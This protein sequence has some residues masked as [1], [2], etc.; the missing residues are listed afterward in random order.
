MSPLVPPGQHGGPDGLIDAEQPVRIDFSSCVNALGPAPEVIAAVRAARLDVYPDP[1]CRAA[2]EAAAAYCQVPPD[3]VTCGAGAAELIL[4]AARA[5]LSPGDLALVCAPAFGEYARAAAMCGAR[6]HE[7]REE[8]TGAIAALIGGLRPRI[9][10]IAC[11]TSPAGRAYERAQLRRVADAC[12][13][14][15]A[16]LVLDQSYD[17]FLDAPL[18][19]PALRGHPAV[20][21]LRSL[22]KDHALAGLR[23]AFAAGPA[24]VIWAM[25]QVRMPW[26]VSAPGQAAIVS[27]LSPVAQAYAARTIAGLRA[28]RVRLEAGCRALGLATLPTATHYFLTRVPDASGVAGRLRR[29]HG[30][31]VRDCASFGLPDHIRV[32]ARTRADNDQLLTALQAVIREDS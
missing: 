22:T 7:L 10:F 3:A 2:T 19:T 15:S 1:R 29:D 23:V 11:P 30:I 13:E 12:E 9:V 17:A 31:A 27:A 8:D 16:L 25:E 28:E 5:W 18:G 32:A 24:G 4:A 20:L 6:V 26:T 14:V 21:A